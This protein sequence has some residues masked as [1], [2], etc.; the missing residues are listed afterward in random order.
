MTDRKPTFINE[1]GDIQEVSPINDYLLVSG[2]S[3]QGN[4]NLKDSTGTITLD[5]IRRRAQHVGPVAVDGRPGHLS[6]SEPSPFKLA[7]SSGSIWSDGFTEE[8]VDAFNS[9]LADRFTVVYRN[10]VGGHTELASQDSVNASHVDLGTGVLY[11][12]TAGFYV[13]HHLYYRKSTSS[14]YLVIAQ[15]EHDGTYESVNSPENIDI[16]AFLKLENNDSIFVFRIT[17]QQGSTSITTLVKNSAGSY[18]QPG[19][20]ITDTDDILEGAVNVFWTA[21]RFTS[22]YEARFNTDFDTRFDAQFPVD[23]DARFSTTFPG[24]FD[25]RFDSQFP[26]D[27][28]ARF[29]AQFPVDFA[30]AYETRFENDFDSR[31]DERANSDLSSIILGL[32]TDM[33][34][35]V[36]LIT[37]YNAPGKKGQFSYGKPTWYTGGYPVFWFCVATN[38]WIDVGEFHTIISLLAGKIGTSDTTDWYLDPS[39][40]TFPNWHLSPGSKDQWTM[41]SGYWYK[42]VARNTVI[43]ILCETA[44]A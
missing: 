5:S 33:F 32:S 42:W 7:I 43:R 36:S 9:S 26:T 30:N 2:I 41:L 4:L 11:N 18:V 20:P 6:I 40:L 22:A 16:P 34:V 37:S 10:G 31:Y 39:V 44:P 27:F 24:A 35:P 38:T 8:V 29:D 14:W 1:D 15:S 13:T 25:E 21:T 19:S 23:F 3:S 28:D 17:V 12:I